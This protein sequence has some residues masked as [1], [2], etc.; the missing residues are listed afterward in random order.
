MANAKVFSILDTKCGF[1][2]ITLDEESSKLTTFTNK[3]ARYKFLCIPNGTV[4]RSEIFQKAIEELFQ[5]I[6]CNILVDDNYMKKINN[7]HIK[8]VKITPKRS[9][10]YIFLT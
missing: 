1:W 9:N 6:S 8:T 2:H 7:E 4:A 10:K 3:F 5:K